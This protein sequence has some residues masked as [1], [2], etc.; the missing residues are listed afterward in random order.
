MFVNIEFWGK[1]RCYAVY[2]RRNRRQTTKGVGRLLCCMFCNVVFCSVNRKLMAG[3]WLFG[4]MLWRPAIAKDG[5][6]TII[7]NGQGWCTSQ[8]TV[9]LKQFTTYI[10]AKVGDTF[11]SAIR[12]NQNLRLI[13][14][15]QR[16]V[17][18]GRYC[19]ISATEHYDTLRFF[20]WRIST[21]K[22]T[23][24]LWWVCPHQFVFGPNFVEK[25]AASKINSNLKK[26]L[27][28]VGCII[29]N[30]IWLF[31]VLMSIQC[32]QNSSWKQTL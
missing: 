20:I 30:A 9:T 16:C 11:R 18:Q 4:C 15:D 25:M 22:P 17:Q 29:I 8:P 19:E 27:F 1:F 13:Q 21:F 23:S 2:E 32:K 6:R 12:K 14:S 7:A 28:Q 24:K 26:W 31:S 10:Y 5:L 3:V